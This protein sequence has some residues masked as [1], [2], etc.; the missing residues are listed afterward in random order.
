MPRV[1]LDTTAFIDIE[2]AVKHRRKDWAAKT[3]ANSFA[4]R[5]E[6]GRPFL[7]IVSVVEILQ[8]L[9]K[10]IANPEKAERFTVSAPISFQFLEVTAEIAYLA[11]KII[12]DL[13][14][15]RQAIGFP[16]SLIAATAIHHGL[17]L[18]TANTR[19]FPRVADLGYSLAL[20]N[21]RSIG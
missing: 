2:R 18:V 8:G 7:S 17:T 13:E 9:H 6:H 5:A 10:D 19:H 14:L 12:A 11:S 1:L 20:Q 15:K 16:D 3:I 21:W 4:Y